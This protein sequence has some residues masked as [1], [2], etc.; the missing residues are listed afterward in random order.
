MAPAPSAT[1]RD[2][3]FALYVPA[4]GTNVRVDG[5]NVV[6]R[7]GNAAYAAAHSTAAD[8]APGAANAASAAPVPI[9]AMLHWLSGSACNRSRM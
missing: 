1:M 7:A 6:Y 2:G 4:A 5:G 3:A 8:A 9:N